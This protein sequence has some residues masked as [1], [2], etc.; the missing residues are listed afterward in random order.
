MPSVRSITFFES[1]ENVEIKINFF[2][3]GKR[4]DVEQHECIKLLPA[5]IKRET[6]KRIARFADLKTLKLF[7]DDGTELLAL[8]SLRFIFI[9]ERHTTSSPAQIRRFNEPQVSELLANQFHNAST[10]TY[11]SVPFQSSFGLNT[12][13]F[14]H[15]IVHTRLLLR[16]GEKKGRRETVKVIKGKQFY[17]RFMYHVTRSTMYFLRTSNSTQ[18]Q[19]R[20]LC[21]VIIANHGMAQQQL[22]FLAKLTRKL[23]RFVKSISVFVRLLV[24]QL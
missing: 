13:N 2:S 1:N 9:F 11:S 20:V 5:F 17:V 4:N 23:F 14:M 12:I 10:Q 21:S 24:A 16:R 6:F 8:A 22:R 3:R 15:P 19:P 18:Q 7:I